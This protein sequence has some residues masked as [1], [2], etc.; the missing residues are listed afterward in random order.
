M[1][2]LRSETFR[3]TSKGTPQG[4]EVPPFF[5]THHG[6]LTPLMSSLTYHNVSTAVR[7][8]R[9]VH[10]AISRPF[11]SSVGKGVKNL[12]P[13]QRSRLLFYFL[14]LGSPITGCTMVP[15]ARVTLSRVFIADVPSRGGSVPSREERMFVAASGAGGHPLRPLLL[16]AYT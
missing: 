5:S 8:V 15:S 10:I 14:C 12:H 4:S 1:E 13:G 7:F 2:H 9:L 6:R 3:T 16:L 11:V